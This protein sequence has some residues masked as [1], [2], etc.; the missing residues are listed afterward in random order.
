MVNQAQQK[1]RPFSFVIVYDVKRFGRLDNDEAG[2]YR[3][4]LR[5]HGVEVLYVGENFSGDSTDDLLRPVKQW[6]V[7]E[8]SK[9]L[10]KVTIRGLLS[11]IEDGYWNGGAPPHGYDLRYESQSTGDGSFL[12]TLRFQ[13]DGTKL[14]LDDAGETVR[15]LGR[16]ERLQVSKRDRSRLALS[17]P[18]RV[19]AV[20]RIFSSSAEDRMGYRSIANALNVR[21]ILSPRGPKWS[22]IYSGV[23]TAS[24]I[25]AI[26]TNPL[27]VGNLVWNR[28]TD[29]RFFRIADGRA[30]ERREAYGA[31]LVPN[32]KED[33][34]SIPEAHPGIVSRRLFEAAQPSR[35]G[36]GSSTDGDGNR[37]PGAHNGRRARYLLSGLVICARCRGRY[38]GCCRTKGKRRKDGSAV[39]TYYYGCG[40]YIRKGRAAC[41]FGPV[42]QE[43]GATGRRGRS[44]SLRVLR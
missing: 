17:S 4:I 41:R 18:E 11:R 40:S 30:L 24:T 12:L 39:R 20:R 26:L 42:A 10:S 15:T 44:D 23:W 5:I 31:R 36:R 33:W 21:G 1:R 14:V 34:T 32:P 27:Y 28:R 35:R 22:H 29:A 38:E 37:R 8:E 25:R 9:D 6:Q 13:P 16:G 2:Y 43:A 3:H 7:R 19:E